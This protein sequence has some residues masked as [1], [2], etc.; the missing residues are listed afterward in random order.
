[1]PLSCPECA[2]PFD[3]SDVDLSTGLARCRPCNRVHDARPALTPRKSAAVLSRPL[4]VT[5]ES[6]GGA[7]TLTYQWYT[8]TVWFMLFFCIVWDSFLVVWYS[9]ALA[10]VGSPDGPDLMRFIFPIA[11][12]AV[13]VG[14]T[15]STIAT[16]FNTSTFT[17][18]RGRFVV[19]HGPVPWFGNVDLPASHVRQLYVVESA[20]RRNRQRTWKLLALA[21]AAG[22]ELLTGLPDLH[23]A[24]YMEARLEAALGVE[25]RPVAGEA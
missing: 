24:Q 19:Q 4:A 25:D 3:A 18:D 5:E 15:Y 10:S 2:T 12:V 23:T 9:A 1:M 6:R 11:H 13:G 14:L 7:F 16:F 20:V 8:H 22:R 17:V 21:P